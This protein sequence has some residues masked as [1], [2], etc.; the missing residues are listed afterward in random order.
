MKE[1]LSTYIIF[2]S[3]NIGIIVII[4][5][6]KYDNGNNYHGFHGTINRKFWFSFTIHKSKL[7]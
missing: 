2:I 5:E 1:T 3:I 7:A 4:F 6:Q